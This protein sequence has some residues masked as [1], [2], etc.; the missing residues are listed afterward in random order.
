M[1]QL[2]FLIIE[3]IKMKEIKRLGKVSIYTCIPRC[4]KAIYSP[5]TMDEKNGGR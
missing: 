2:F 3:A 1:F 4:E 5:Y